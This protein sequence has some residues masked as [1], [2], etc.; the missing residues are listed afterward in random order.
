MQRQIALVDLWGIKNRLKAMRRIPPVSA[1]GLKTLGPAA[2]G[3]EFF[4][5]I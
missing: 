5:Q 4:Q 3:F 2:S 1:S